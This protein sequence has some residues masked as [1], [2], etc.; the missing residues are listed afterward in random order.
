MLVM[1]WEGYDLVFHPLAILIIWQALHD[2]LELLR[3]HW[4]SRIPRRL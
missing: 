3:I 1:L 4:I 2:V